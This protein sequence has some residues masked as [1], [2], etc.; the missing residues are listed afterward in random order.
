V[1]ELRN[2]NPSSPAPR[3]FKHPREQND[4]KRVLVGVILLAVIALPACPDR[5]IC[6]AVRLATC[7]ECNPPSEEGLCGEVESA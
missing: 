4:T 6:R 7:P 3:L 5:S 2:L 1:R